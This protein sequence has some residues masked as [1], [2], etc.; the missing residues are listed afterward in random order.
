MP[1]LAGRA[2]A[3]DTIGSIGGELGRS[4]ERIGRGILGLTEKSLT[5]GLGLVTGE[6]GVLLGYMV[7]LSEK[8]FRNIDEVY[9]C[10][11]LYHLKHQ[12]RP[13]QSWKDR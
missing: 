6:A 12:L 4:V 8:E 10:T 11:D 2:G 7:N 3:A 1:L 9:R 13:R 5:L